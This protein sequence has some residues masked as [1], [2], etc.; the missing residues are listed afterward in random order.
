MRQITLAAAFALAAGPAFALD[1][2]VEKKSFTL[3]DFTTEGGVTIPEMT[4]G[5]ETY[6]TLNEAKDNAILITHFFSGNSH[7][8]GKYAESDPAPGYWDA[9]IGP[10]LPIDTDR[11]FVVAADTPV[12]LGAKNPNVITTGPATV[13]PATGKAWGMDFPIMTIGDFVETQR[14]LME[15]LGIG[16]WHAVMGP[17]MGGLQAYDWAARHPDRLGRVIPVIASG[18]ADANLIAWLDI[19]ASPIRLDPN[20][21]G[22]DYYEGTPPDEGLAQALKIV[23]LHAASPDFYNPTFGREWAA[24]GAD[25]GQSWDS[26]YKVVQNGNEGGA[27]RAATADANHLLYLARAN[28]LFV[29]G[30]GDDPEA[31]LKAIDVPVLLIHS[32]GDQ[33]FPGEAVR[34]TAGIIGSDGT[35][36]EIVELEGNMGHLDGVVSIAQAGDRIRAFLDAE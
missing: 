36:V 7:A 6:G 11:Y 24:E 35:P 13:N 17:S 28:Q 25:P 5:Y 26:E 14:G 18:W 27:T 22:G 33:V 30:G 31:A 29:P 19:W 21:N 34:E 2:I 8:A 23:S 4:L 32:N 10:G 9:I 15:Q 12:N 3:T 20:W 1:E 16:K